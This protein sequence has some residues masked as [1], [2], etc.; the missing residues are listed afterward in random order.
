MTEVAVGGSTWLVGGKGSNR[1]SGDKQQQQQPKQ[2]LVGGLLKTPTIGRL[3]VG[4]S[5]D[6]W[7]CGALAV[8]MN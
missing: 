1:W 2:Q 5:M 7:T 4:W 6:T 3:P 8:T